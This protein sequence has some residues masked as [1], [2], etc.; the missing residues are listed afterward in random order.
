MH[1]IFER[2]LISQTNV[3][4]KGTIINCKDFDNSITNSSRVVLRENDTAVNIHHFH[5]ES[6]ETSSTTVGTIL[7]DNLVDVVHGI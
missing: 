3:S 2:I 5:V 1:T 7:D 6:F 4:A